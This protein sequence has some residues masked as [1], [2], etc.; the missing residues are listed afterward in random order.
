MSKTINMNIPLF[1]HGVQQLSFHDCVCARA[2]GL[3]QFGQRRQHSHRSE[4][5]FV[6]H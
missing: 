3:A 2:G 4:E 1:C 6:V 5:E